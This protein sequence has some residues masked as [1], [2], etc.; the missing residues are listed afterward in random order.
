MGIT[1][2]VFDL[3]SVIAYYAIRIGLLSYHASRIICVD[4]HQET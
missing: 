2:I 1:L 4:E 3:R